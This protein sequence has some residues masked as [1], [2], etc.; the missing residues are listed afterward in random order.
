MYLSGR[1]KLGANKTKA[2][3]EGKGMCFGAGMKIIW[4][5]GSNLFILQLTI[6]YKRV[7]SFKVHYLFTGQLFTR[8][9]YIED[10]IKFTDV[11]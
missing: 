5:G 6:C 4:G 10:Y 11:I 3:F 1:N 8:Q 2:F 9:Y 7:Q